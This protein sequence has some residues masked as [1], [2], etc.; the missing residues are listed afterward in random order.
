MGPLNF[1]VPMGCMVGYIGENGSGKSTTLKSIL[2]LI[3]PDSGEIEIFGK[4]IKEHEPALM[5]RIGDSFAGIIEL[6][7]NIRQASAWVVAGLVY[8]VAIF[9]LIVSQN[10]G[11]A[12]I[13]AK[14][15]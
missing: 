12:I 9:A 15:Y 1:N 2:G 4:N 3:H 11:I 5:N 13:K 7:Q 10:I 14:E 8:V 6:I